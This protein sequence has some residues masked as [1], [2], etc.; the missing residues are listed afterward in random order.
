M[1]EGRKAKFKAHGSL[2]H[3]A[4]LKRNAWESRGRK[5]REQA[6]DR[7]RVI[8]AEPDDL[9]L[10]DG[11]AAMQALLVLSQM[12]ISDSPVISDHLQALFRFISHPDG[13]VQPL[14]AQGLMSLLNR[15]LLSGGAPH[16]QLCAAKCMTS[17]AGGDHSVTIQLLPA[18]PSLLGQLLLT[19]SASPSAS[20]LRGQIC[21]VLGNIAIDCSSCQ[22]A[23]A[24][25]GAPQ[26]VLRILLLCAGRPEAGPVDL[27]GD[28]LWCLTNMVRGPAAV[29]FMSLFR[30]D[31]LAVLLQLLSTEEV[32]VMAAWLL[33]YL[34]SK[35][36]DALL[37][38]LLG[39]GLQEALS[40]QLLLALPQG[41]GEGVEGL[42]AEGLVALLRCL[43]NICS[44]SDAAAQSALAL[45]PALIGLLHPLRGAPHT[46]K[47]VLRTLSYLLQDTSS[48]AQEAV[49][50]EGRGAA[51][52]SA[53]HAHL[54]GGAHALQEACLLGIEPVLP[55][56]SLGYY[57][58]VQGGQLSE[59]L[60]AMAQV[61]LSASAF[62]QLAALSLLRQWLAFAP[63]LMARQLQALDLAE[64]LENMQYTSE[65]VRVRE[66]AQR[67]LDML[68]QQM[69][70]EEDKEEE[71]QGV[72]GQG[73][74]VFSFG[75]PQEVL[76]GAGRGARAVQPAWMSNAP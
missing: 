62:A 56:H 1:S 71:V 26:E 63:A 49:F 32:R 50:A 8:C 20:A 58:E 6:I 74:N 73:V 39:L 55:Q 69:E 24:A 43:G 53:W 65:E 67:V 41:C 76:R 57:Q 16:A 47:E 36:D 59:A 18:V 37:G 11:A 46:T 27:L 68:Y 5:N 72:Q 7:K 34:T 22:A 61:L 17:I 66:L 13:Q 9:M 52:M 28:L 12:E 42:E 48:E 40:R 35:D 31:E 23:L 54:L 60:L 19:P 29:P 30:D 21:W 45:A 15:C 4:D 25:A 64:S 3:S 10:A 2:L 75:T 14:L 51:Y 70:A 33:T 38:R 44:A